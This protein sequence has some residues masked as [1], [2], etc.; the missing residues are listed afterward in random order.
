MR[1]QL[2]ILTLLSALNLSAQ[3]DTIEYVDEGFMRYENHIYRKNIK[4]VK[5][6]EESLQ[7]TSPILKL[8]SESRLRFSFDDM[9]AD[10]KEYRYTLIHCDAAW[11]PSNI[12]KMEY[13][14][15]FTEDY[16]TNYR[17][18][19]NTLKRYTHYDLY[20]P[21]E[22]MNM[23]ISGNYLLKVYL[24]DNEEQALITRR[25]IVYENLVQTKMKVGRATVINDRNYKQEIDFEITYENYQITNPYGDI[26][27]VLLQNGRWD[28]AIYNLKPVFIQ[29]NKLIYDHETGNVFSGGNEYRNFDM[30]S[31]RFITNEIKSFTY[32]S[33]GNHVHLLDDEKRAFKQYFSTADINGKYLIKTD[34]GDDDDVEGDYGYV[35]FF[36]PYESPIREG[37][38]YVFGELSD[39]RTT[40]E[41]KMKYNYEREGYEARILLKQGYYNYEYV[42]MKDG[43]EAADN[44][45]IEGMHFETENDYLL[46]V[47][48]KN[49]RNNYFRIVGIQSINTLRPN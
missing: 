33:L 10:L 29:N 34:E 9:D 22:N 41:F 35:H 27:V 1:L 24:P 42:I 6:H 8:G 13:L 12:N 30:K 48:H 17:Y 32:D 11:N 15:G 25:F 39:W 49:E 7:L 14:N 31:F 36:L 45:F 5:L 26:E 21:N 20:L 47:Y 46:L 19:Y 18:S 44:S 37:N 23:R 38:L 4:S 3:V 2:L 40:P 43:A 16:I 28:N